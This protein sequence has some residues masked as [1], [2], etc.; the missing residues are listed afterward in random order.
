MP[1][2]VWRSALQEA[3]HAGYGFLLAFGLTWMLSGWVW[4]RWSPQAGVVAVLAQDFVA[5]P[6]ALTLSMVDSGGPRPSDPVLDSVSI[7][8]LSGQLLAIPVVLVLVARRRFSLATGLLS[9]VVTV[10]FVPY[11]WLY[12][13]LVYP[14]VGLA[15]VVGV[16]VVMLRHPQADRTGEERAGGL[17]ALATGL[18]LFLG[19]VLLRLTY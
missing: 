10:H 11:G 4:R 8:L 5:L 6:V 19:G 12:D 18:P 2:D 3:S 1:V 13:T 9:V 7:Y 16:C 15:C 17:I 14:V